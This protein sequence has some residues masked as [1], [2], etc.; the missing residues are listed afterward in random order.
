MDLYR[1]GSKKRWHCP[2]DIFNYRAYAALMR[3][4]VN[5]SAFVAVSQGVRL[6]IQN[7]PGTL[8]VG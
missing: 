8:S 6:S 7:P 1:I 5:I 3:A 2:A 4:N